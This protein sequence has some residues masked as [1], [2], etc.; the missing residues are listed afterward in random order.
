MFVPH[1]AEKGFVVLQKSGRSKIP[2]E[3][4]EDVGVDLGAGSC[5]RWSG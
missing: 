5:L 4:A 2:H 3:D 1:D